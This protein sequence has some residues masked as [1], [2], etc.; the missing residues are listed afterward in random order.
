MTFREALTKAYLITEVK[1]AA[2]YLSRKTDV[3]NQ[4]LKEGK[5]KRKG[6][7]YIEVPH[8]NSTRYHLRVYM[9]QGETPKEEITRREKETQE[10]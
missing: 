1:T 4:E 10:A 8:F 7:W 3:Y 6:E 5:G 9:R 2:G